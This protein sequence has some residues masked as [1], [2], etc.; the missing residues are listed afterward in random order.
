MLPVRGL[1]SMTFAALATSSAFA[2]DSSKLAHEAAA[3][4]ER[5]DVVMYECGS[6]ISS[7]NGPVMGAQAPAIVT[8]PHDASNDDASN[9][10]DLYVR[11]GFLAPR[12]VP[13]YEKLTK[14]AE[15]MEGGQWSSEHYLVFT[16]WMTG[17]GMARIQMKSTGDDQVAANCVSVETL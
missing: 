6:F 10:K 14:V 15:Y 16:M 5:Q 4:G 13:Q 1:H 3:A 11:T 8:V 7:K 9:G 2:G 17:K 12:A